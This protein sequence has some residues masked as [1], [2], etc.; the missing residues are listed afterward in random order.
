MAWLEEPMKYQEK[1]LSWVINAVGDDLR[2]VHACGMG[3]GD[4]IKLS[5]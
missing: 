5:A 2:Q 1:E 3:E 4:R